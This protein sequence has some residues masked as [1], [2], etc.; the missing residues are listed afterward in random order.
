MS[1]ILSNIQNRAGLV[2]AL[3]DIDIAVPARIEGRKTRH[4]ETYIAC[5]LLSTLTEANLLTFPLSVTRR[6][7]PND[8]PDVVMHT[9][10]AQVGIEITEAI[11]ERFAALCAFAEKEFPGHWLPVE[12]FP[13]DAEA[14]SKEEMRDLL[15]D[16]RIVGG[17]IGNAPEKEWALFMNGVVKT[18]L[19][20]LANDGFQKFDQN[21]LSVY[22]NLPLPT[23]HLGEAIKL[24]RPLLK[25]LWASVPAFDT[26]FIE[27][28][29][30]IAKIT[31]NEP[32]HIV[33]N[34]LW[35]GQRNV[36]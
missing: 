11:P 33:I 19:G 22:D 2:A 7:P 24:L 31:A 3:R 35:C 17:W 36:A 21:W 13:W 16:A 34:D 32:E 20:K 10:N 30:V 9:G 4:T 27:H 12:Q 5:R 26:L 18:K 1:L 23:V 28:G 15:K 6:D 29:P 25:D 8:R 14:L